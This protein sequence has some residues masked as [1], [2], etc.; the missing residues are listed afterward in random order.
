MTSKPR[1]TRQNKEISE[2]DWKNTPRANGWQN[3]I[4]TNTRHGVAGALG[5]SFRHWEQSPVWLRG[6]GS[7]GDI[8]SSLQRWDG[9]EA[10]PR[11]RL[12]R[13]CS[14]IAFPLFQHSW[15]PASTSEV[16][17]YFSLIRTFPPKRHQPR[18][19]SHIKAPE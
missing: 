15:P 10:Q 8:A 1:F 2:P 5:S 13:Y 4:I 6:F 18:G 17:F 3:I 19:W 9:L 7:S 14:Q 11:G 16:A 12:G